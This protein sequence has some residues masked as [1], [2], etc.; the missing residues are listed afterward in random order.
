MIDVPGTP[1]AGGLPPMPWVN[2]LAN[3][4]FGTLVTERGAAHT[5]SRNSR[6]HR[7]TPW[8]ND[9]ILDPHGEALYVRDEDAGAF[10]SPQPGPAPGGSAL[11]GAPRLRQRR[12]GA[13]AATTSI[14]R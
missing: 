8:S 12:A 14:R 2:V 1:E 9:P 10:W 7:L 11:R 6:E 3:P 13:T 4:S 5:W